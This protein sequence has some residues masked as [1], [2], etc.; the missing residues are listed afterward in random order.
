MQRENINTQ[1][2][3]LA[4]RTKSMMRFFHWPSPSSAILF[5]AMRIVHFTYCVFLLCVLNRKFDLFLFRSTIHNLPLFYTEPTKQEEWSWQY[6][7]SHSHGQMSQVFT[8]LDFFFFYKCGN[9]TSRFNM[10]PFSSKSCFIK[11]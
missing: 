10:T 11:P 4:W 3:L 6:H 5:L 1:M 9:C 7:L 2:P 8:I